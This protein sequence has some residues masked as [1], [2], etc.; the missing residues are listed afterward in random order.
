MA[1]I[2]LKNIGKTYPGNVTVIRDLNLEINDKEF[3]VYI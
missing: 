3:V 1:G 2:S